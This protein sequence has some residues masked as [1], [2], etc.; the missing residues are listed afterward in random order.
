MK[1]K[2]FTLIEVLIA[3]TLL[4]ILS[5]IA[6]PSFISISQSNQSAGSTNAI[7]SAFYYAKQEAISKRRSV[8]LCGSDNKTSCNNLT[9]W[10]KGFIVFNDPNKNGTLDAGEVILQIFADSKPNLEL[11]ANQKTFY[12]NF[13]GATN[14]TSDFTLTFKMDNCKSANN[15]LMTVKTF[16]RMTVENKECDA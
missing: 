6:I 5:M 4:G 8:S 3:V 11:T 12:F 7:L 1:N 2:G 9:D 10:S 13:S 15:K 16:G 14:L